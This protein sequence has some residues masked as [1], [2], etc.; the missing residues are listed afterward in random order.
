[1]DSCCW[2]SY[3]YD[4]EYLGSVNAR[5]FLASWSTVSYA[6]MVFLHGAR[7]YFESKNL[8]KVKLYRILNSDS[9]IEFSELTV[10]HKPE[11]E[12]A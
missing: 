8:V 5:N 10:K 7:K 9:I 11:E 3:E 1:L 4:N 2:G 6:R 12:I